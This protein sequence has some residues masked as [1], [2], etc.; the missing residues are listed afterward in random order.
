MRRLKVEIIEGLAQAK[1]R[2]SRQT[3]VESS[4]VSPLIKSRLQEV[5]GK[6]ITPEQA[7]AKIL[8]D[9]HTKGDAALLDYTCKID[10]F[11]PSSLEITREQIKEAY[12]QVDRELV[13]ALETA[14]ERIRQ[15]H[16]EQKSYIFQGV[17]GKEW[18]QLVR[19][20]ERVGV[21]APGGTASYPSTVLM[22]AIP[23]KVA[24]VKEVI[25]TTPPRNAGFVPLATLV[26][27]D[28]AG[29]DRIFGIGGAQA[30]AALA[31]GTE[32]VPRVDKICGPGNIFVALAKKMVFGTVDIDGIM[33]PSEVLVIADGY[34]KAEY[35]A[36]DLLA[37]AE[38]DV[39]AQVV[40]VTTSKKFARAVEQELK[41][42]LA[43]LPR[44]KIAAESLENRS[45]IAIV[46][47]ID[48]AIE[49]ANLYAPEHLELMVRDAESYVEKITS[50]GCIF[51][52]ENSTVPMG[53]Y[54]AGPNHSLPTGGTARFGS[55]LNI[56]DFIKF[57]DVVK[58]NKRS[59]KK[60]GRAAITLARAEGLEA[61]ARAIERRLNSKGKKG[62]EPLHS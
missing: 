14:A 25:L 45:I 38:H 13:A 20:L 62:S 33:G 5:F 37:Q 46:F 21:Y 60:L 32:S 58:M 18:G 57:I 40:L 12:R 51:I 8:Q 29:V 30:I 6:N 41:L 44:R 43:D 35:C 24:G 19:P 2:L 61:H 15:F 53:D 17:V 23:A 48:E 7:V 27:A 52:G 34:A 9:I 50:A 59:L 49:L 11:K 3:I 1:A 54:V 26:A 16:Q 22:T 28:I 47:C 36:A 39:L 42:Q 56:V 4:T 31:Y 55:P 10:G